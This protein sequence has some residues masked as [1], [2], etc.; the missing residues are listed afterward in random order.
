MPR[1]TRRQAKQRVSHL[2]TL[3]VCAPWALAASPFFAEPHKP[4]LPLLQAVVS[5]YLQ[6]EGHLRT[7]RAKGELAMLHGASAALLGWC[8]A[9]GLAP[10]ALPRRLTRLSSAG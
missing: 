2:S 1:H 7:S 8:R 10:N 4:W 5:D 6:S 9:I 3:V